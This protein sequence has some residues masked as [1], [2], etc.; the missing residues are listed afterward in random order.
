VTIGKGVY[1]NFNCCLLDCAPISIGD[2]VLFGP[3]VQVSNLAQVQ[4]I[5]STSCIAF[6]HVHANTCTC[7]QASQP[8]WPSLHE[9]P[10]IMMFIHFSLH[11]SRTAP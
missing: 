11:V 2:N 8:Y 5:L 6:C 4:N 7:D 1:M 3:N 9:G 10:N